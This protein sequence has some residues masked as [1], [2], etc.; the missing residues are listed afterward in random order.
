[1]P[2]SHPWQELARRLGEDRLERDVLLASHT[3]FKIGGPADVMYRALNADEL[4]AAIQAARE[5]EIP[6]FLLG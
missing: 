5:L 2:S 6:F 1:M 3:T 4:A